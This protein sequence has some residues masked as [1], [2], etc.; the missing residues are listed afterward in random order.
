MARVSIMTADKVLPCPPPPGIVGSV[1]CSSYFN[2]ASDP[3]HLTLL[4]LPAGETMAMTPVSADRL[5]YVWEGA[6]E[7]GGRMLGHGS[8]L[9]VE[10]RAALTVTARDGEAAILLFSG[11]RLPDHPRAGGHV[12]LLP[13]ESVPRV[14][15]T[16]SGTSGALHSDGSC[17]TCELWLNENALAGRTEAPTEGQVRLGARLFDRGTA[18]AIA[19]HTLYGFSPGPE[20]MRFITF[21]PG[22]ADS[23]RFASGGDYAPSTYFSGI[24]RI[25]WLEPVGA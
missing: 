21:R 23:I 11:G 13:Y 1:L 18:L 9:I 24:G 17:P 12:H 15:A 7:A 6:V 25:P 22:S 4:R 5:A 14:P 3:A 19:A 10:H 8:S 20:G 16:A 2:G